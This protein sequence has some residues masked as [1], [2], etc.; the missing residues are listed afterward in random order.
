MFLRV[1]ALFGVKKSSFFLVFGHFFINFVAEME[2]MIAGYEMKKLS[3]RTY[4]NG[5]AEILS[6]TYA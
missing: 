2:I 1:W 4:R 6:C 3:A 5:S